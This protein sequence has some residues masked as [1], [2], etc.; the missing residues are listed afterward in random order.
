MCHRDFASQL[1]CLEYSLLN[2]LEFNEKGT[3]NSLPPCWEYLVQRQST[4]QPTT[5]QHIQKSSD[6]KRID[7]GPIL[8]LAK[9]LHFN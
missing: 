2:C 4:R 6:L 1:I 7:N 3:K 8:Q 5:T 9:T